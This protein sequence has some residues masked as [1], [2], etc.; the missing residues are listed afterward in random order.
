M[1]IDD[2]DVTMENQQEYSDKIKELEEEL[3]DTFSAYFDLVSIANNEDDDDVIEMSDDEEEQASTSSLDTTQKIRI[4]FRNYEPRDYNLK[5]YVKKHSIYSF[6]DE[7]SSRKVTYYDTIEEATEQILQQT[8]I[9]IIEQARAAAQQTGD[10]TL[11][12]IPQKI[13]YDLKRDVTKKLELLEK[14]T[15]KALAE[16]LKEK[17]SLEEEEESSDDE[18]EEESDTEMNSDE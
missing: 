2:D 18:E 9:P 15:M 4:T 5:K 12:L 16:I 1:T 7:S 17:L 6:E 10:A 11:H 8:V 3:D 14:R 13:N